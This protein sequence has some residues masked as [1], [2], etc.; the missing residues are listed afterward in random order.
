MPHRPMPCS[1]D[2]IIPEDV[3]HLYMHV[4]AHRLG[5]SA[6]ARMA[7]LTS[8]QILAGIMKQVRI[9]VKMR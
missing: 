7:N 8:E 5:P 9:P 6:E 3:Q 2:Y 1:P 4:L